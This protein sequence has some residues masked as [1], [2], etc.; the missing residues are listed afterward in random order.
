MDPATLDA[1]IL[2]LA[3]VVLPLIVLG[4]LADR[5]GA[6]S[7]DLGLCDFGAATRNR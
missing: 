7:R 3:A 4:F 6:D 1:I 5:I 2:F